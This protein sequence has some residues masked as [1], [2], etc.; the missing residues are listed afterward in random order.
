MTYYPKIDKKTGKKVDQEYIDL[1]NPDK[2]K[3]K[4]FVFEDEDDLEDYNTYAYGSYNYD[5]SY[6]PDYAESNKKL[7]IIDSLESISGGDFSELREI[8]KTKDT[9]DWHKAQ[10]ELYNK[11]GEWR[12]YSY[13]QPPELDY[14]Y[15]EQMANA[16]SSQYKVNI[17]ASDKWAIDLDKKTLLYNPDDLLT[18]SKA[19]VLNSLLHEIGHLR[20]TTSY[21]KLKGAFYDKPEYQAGCQEV[22]SVFEDFRVDK[23]MVKSYPSAEDIYKHNEPD[24]RALA[25]TIENKQ[26]EKIRYVLT[27]YVNEVRQ[28]YSENDG[29][30]IC[31]LLNCRPEELRITDPK[32]PEISLSAGNYGSA[33]HYDKVQDLLEI[34]HRQLRDKLIK[35]EKNLFNYCAV[36]CLAG[37]GQKIKPAEAIK[38]F[39]DKTMPAIKKCQ[40]AKDTQSLVNILESEVYPVIEE[41]LTIPSKDEIEKILGKKGADR[42]AKMYSESEQ[43]NGAV[44]GGTR[45]YGNKEVPPSWRRGD[46]DSLKKSVFRPI[47]ELIKKLNFVKSVQGSPAYVNRQRRGRLDIKQAYKF[48]VSGNDRIFKRK[49]ESVEKIRNHAFEVLIDISGSMRDQ[50][51]IVQATR[52]LVV[53]AEVFDYMRVNYAI[54]TFNTK[55]HII[56]DYDDKL[57]SDMKRKIGSLVNMAGGGTKITDS[58]NKS[59]LAKQPQRNKIRIILT[60]GGLWLD[61]VIH[62]KQNKAVKQIGFT[63]AENDKDFIEACG[64]GRYIKQAY[65]LPIAFEETIKN[66]L[67]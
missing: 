12:G 46:Y 1:F 29:E 62:A 44:A 24:I 33:M 66:I 48:R 16:L 31:E 60:D 18:S 38:P 41:L 25:K 7:E 57:D 50:N 55:N 4:R 10:M 51:R 15:I 8:E 21:T 59:K 58:L 11:T 63:L 37:Y 45:K 13:Y 26:E 56:K 19:R 43:Q 20:H 2:K 9:S 49:L 52:S 32:N 67:I 27:R 61:P 28:A 30:K 3:Q 64:Q 22:I 14:R 42:L 47:Q 34:R 40:N 6:T 35:E 17:E 53:M 5:W 39:V 65:D 36:M 23:I 54:S